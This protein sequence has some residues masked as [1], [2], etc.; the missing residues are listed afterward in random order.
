MRRLVLLVVGV[1]FF[2][3][4]DKKESYD[5]LP[6]DL[7]DFEK[8]LELMETWDLSGD[9]IDE[10]TIR[11][12]LYENLE[13]RFKKYSLLFDL[14]GESKFQDEYTVEEDSVLFFRRL[15]LSGTISKGS[16]NR[17][18]YMLL[19]SHID[20][21]DF[22]ELAVSERKLYF[23]DLRKLS[24]QEKALDTVPYTTRQFDKQDYRKANETLKFIISSISK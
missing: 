19:E 20:F 10:G 1:I 16:T 13:F 21:R 18:Q 7:R 5:Y 2:T 24:I 14:E 17:Q 23:N 3:S 12:E 8:N 11:L 22:S 15:G 9:S 6:E 4:C